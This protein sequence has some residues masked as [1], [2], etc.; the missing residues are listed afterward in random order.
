MVAALEHLDTIIR[1]ALGRSVHGDPLGSSSSTASSSTGAHAKSFWT[2]SSD[3]AIALLT[4][5]LFFFLAWIVLLIVKLVLGMLLLRYARR[6][7]AVMVHKEKMQQ[8]HQ[9]QQDEAA[10]E[11]ELPLSQPGSKRIGAWGATEV[12]DDRRR[13]LYDDDPDGLRR[14]RERERKTE[15]KFREISKGGADD[16]LARVCRYE[17]G[18]SKRIW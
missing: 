10:R 7:Y 9:Q 4:M 1:N 13:W 17:M 6:R 16:G 11:R 3:D 14:M 12:G 8:H 18:V 2:F 5:L 15:E